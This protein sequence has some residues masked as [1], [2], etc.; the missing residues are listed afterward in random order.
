M[1]FELSSFFPPPRY[2]QMPAVGIDIS[3]RSLKFVEIVE[4]KGE[5]RLGR[6]GKRTLPEGLI[7]AGE[8]KNKEKLAEFIKTNFQ[9]VTGSFV[10]LA[11]PE[12]KAYVSHISLPKLKKEEIRD[13]LELQLEE[14]IPLPAS[15]AVFDYEVVSGEKEDHTD[16]V[17]VAFGRSLVENY[18]EVMNGAGLRPIVFE[19]EAEALRR[20]V[21]PRQANGTKMIIDFGR[22]RTSFIIVSEGVVRFTS[23]V[24]VA[25]EGLDRAIGRALKVDAHEAERAKKEQGLVRTEKNKAI[26]NAILP[27]V[28]AIKDEVLRHM[29]YWKNHAEHLHGGN[30]EIDILYLSG[31]DSNLTGF[32]DYLSYELKVPVKLASP[33]VNIT[34]FERYIPEIAHNESLYYATAIGLALRSRYIV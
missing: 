16:V 27:I 2:L 7:Q 25:G 14:Y 19:L 9:E 30:T 13:A 4:V 28:S 32:S 11:L 20:A 26:F 6:F 29:A 12:E 1:S 18:L 5:L 10:V 23:T 8:I 3:D 24:G 33:W 15:Q 22:T 34:D 17:A 21:L 31:G